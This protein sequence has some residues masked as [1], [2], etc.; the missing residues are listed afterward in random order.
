M[1]DLFHGEKNGQRIGR[2]SN[3]VVMHVEKRNKKIL[4]F[5]NNL[6]THDASYWKDITPNDEVVA[7]YCIE[8]NWL[9]PTSYGWKKMEVFR[10]KFLLETLHVL[11]QNLSKFGIQ[12]YIFQKTASEA[13]RDIYNEFPFDTIISQN[14]WTSEER[15]IEN[16]IKATFPN[17]NWNTFYDQFLIHPE[18]LPFSIQDLPNVFT[19]YRKKVE[20]SWNVKNCIEL[21]NEKFISPVL[22]FSTEIPTLEELG[23]E[24][25]SID[26]RSAFPFQGG[27]NSA[28]KHLKN[29]IWE[30]QQIKTY[31]ETRNE[32]VGVNY[33]TKFSAWLANGSLSPRIIY[34]EIRKFEEEVIANESTYWV[35]FELLWR[36]FFKCVSLKFGDVLFYQSGILDRKYHWKQNPTII[37]NWIDGKTE[38]DFVNANMLELKLTGWMSNRGRQNVASYFAKEKE[39][40]WRIGASYFE[41][42]LIDYDVH[43]N[44]GNWNYLAGVG[45]DPRDRKFNIDLQAKNYDSFHVFRNLWLTKNKVEV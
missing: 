38:Y 42:M 27:E 16:E 20:Q 45:N 39:Q 35:L 43:S 24:S 14:E 34:Q 22:S 21:P 15:A 3:I 40:D 12:L 13:F 9:Q 41:A 30:F 31:K 18:D 10:A 1:S 23:Y 5:R 4:W 33:S 36:D 44:Y 8:P 19:A 29:Y 2:K 17:V 37:Q 11:Q 26:H 6:R 7:V 28:L 32:L 25:I